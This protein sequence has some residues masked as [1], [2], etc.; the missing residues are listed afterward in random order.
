MGT[1]K[2]C[3]QKMDPRRACVCVCRSVC[4]RVRAALTVLTVRGSREGWANGLRVVRERNRRIPQRRNR[5]EKP[6]TCRLL[7]PS[8]DYFHIHKHLMRPYAQFTWS[9]PIRRPNG[10]RTT[11]SSP[12]VSPPHG[13]GER[14]SQCH[15]PAGKGR[16]SSWGQLRLQGPGTG[17]TAHTEPIDSV[18]L[19]TAVLVPRRW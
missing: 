4:V 9:R 2:Y 19:E 15:P 12:T 7:R 3:S 11:S 10:V 18:Q 14:Y 6:L 1:D 13:H 8:S 16:P 17:P 5:P